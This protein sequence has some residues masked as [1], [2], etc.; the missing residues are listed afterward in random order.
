MNSSRRF[1]LWISGILA[2][3]C[4]LLL[5]GLVRQFREGPRPKLVTV[6]LSRSVS[7][8]EH[9][10]T[11]SREHH[12]PRRV[13]GDAGAVRPSTLLRAVPSALLRDAERSRSVSASRIAEPPLRARSARNPFASRQAKRI[14]SMP[15]A[16]AQPQAVAPPQPKTITLEPLGYV[17]KADGRVEA[18]ISLGD[19]VHVVHEGEIFEDNFR[20]AKISSS[21]VELVENSAP[22]VD[23]QLKAEI[24]QGGGPVPGGKAPQMPLRP[25]PELVSSADANRPFAADVAAGGSQPSLRQELGYVERADGRVEAIVAEGEHVRLAPA[26]KS[27]ASSFHVPAPSPANL[28]LANALPPPINPPNSLALESQPLQTKS[29]PREAGAAPPL[30]ALGPEPSAV[31]KPQGIPAN[32]GESESELLGVIQS[33]PLADYSGTR[34]EPRDVAPVLPAGPPGAAPSP[35]TAGA[36]QALM[37]GAAPPLPSDGRE[38]QPAVNTLGYVEKAGG[39]KEAI[40]EALGQIYL[41][42]E[43]EL[44][45]EKYRALQ[46]SSS[47]V[48]IV[49]ESTKGSSLPSEMERDSGALRPPISRWRAPPL[50]A[51]SSGTDPPVEVRR[52]EGLAASEPVV[53]PSRPPP[54]HPVES[55]QRPKAAEPRWT[56]LESVRSVQRLGHIG[57]RSPPCAF[58]TVGFVEKAGGEAEATVAD[59]GVVCLVPGGRLYLDNP[60]I[61]RLFPAEPQASRESIQGLLPGMPNTNFR[62]DTPK[63]HSHSP[64]A[65]A[66]TMQLDSI[67]PL[68]RC[69]QCSSAPHPAQAGIQGGVSLSRLV[70]AAV[71]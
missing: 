18:I 66:G 46:V 71:P 54:E 15:P 60:K 3:A 7:I 30:T 39:E 11:S 64:P 42:H 4:L 19:R 59:D 8:A 50:S 36:G 5:N 13:G 45:A 14:I 2:V 1:E 27:F 38:T 56:A 6:D 55:L 47:S 24:G 69:S 21:A 49:E 34:F 51:A 33:E 57:T 20:V 28:E 26:S 35:A 70:A 62:L 43:G 17:E 48:K 12:V 16:R 25:V 32:H 31:D 10:P 41:V 61:P 53:S 40:V 63:T 58:D 22:S 37:G 52:A 9:P 44:F 29:S 23:S 68:P 67:V 65:F